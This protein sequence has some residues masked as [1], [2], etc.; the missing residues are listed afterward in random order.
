M[1]NAN[2]F[3]N[4]NDVADDNIF[5]IDLGSPELDNN[6]PEGEYVGK[7]ID[8]IKST[9]KSSG[10]PMWVFT[11]T[12]IEGPYAGEDFKVFCA[13]TPAAIWKLT[14]TLNALG[15]VV[16]GQPTKFGKADVLNTMVKMVIIMGEYNGSPRSELKAVLPW[17]PVGKKH[18]GGVVPGM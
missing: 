18:T 7:C 8:V 4:P 16:Q 9:A 5:E 13:I 17:E 14:E 1:S 11:F 6:V 10:N 3:G 2:P 15:L 12:I